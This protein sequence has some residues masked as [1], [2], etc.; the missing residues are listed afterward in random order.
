VEI[1][2]S[3]SD[4]GNNAGLPSPMNEMKL[5]DL[6]LLGLTSATQP[7]FGEIHVRGPN[8]FTGYYGDSARTYGPR[9][10]QHHYASGL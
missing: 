6:P 5:V 2:V 7:E 4:D 9:L 1:G 8:V 3:T 10:A